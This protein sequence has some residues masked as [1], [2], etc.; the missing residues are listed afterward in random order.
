MS[1]DDLRFWRNSLTSS[2][3]RYIGHYGPQG[4]KAAAHVAL[5]LADA[6]LAQRRT[7]QENEGG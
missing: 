5:N 3:D 6:A 1:E 7:R 2:L 4:A